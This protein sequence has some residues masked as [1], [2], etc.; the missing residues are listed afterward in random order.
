MSTYGIKFSFYDFA[1]VKINL[2]YFNFNFNY[3]FINNFV[4]TFRKILNIMKKF[5]IILLIINSS[6][7]VHCVHITKY[8]KVQYVY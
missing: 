2:L 1:A 5:S 3:N 6:L 7:C 8:V 4:E